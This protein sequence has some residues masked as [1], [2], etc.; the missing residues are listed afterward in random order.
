LLNESG[1]AKCSRF[2]REKNTKIGKI[3]RDGIKFATIGLFSL[4]EPG[5]RDDL[6]RDPGTANEAAKRQIRLHDLRIRG[7]ALVRS[8][9][10]RWLAAGNQASDPVGAP[11]HHG[12]G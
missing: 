11:E 2:C 3:R 12:S 10:L 8:Q 1:D 9:R 5:L 4:P 6:C 7:L